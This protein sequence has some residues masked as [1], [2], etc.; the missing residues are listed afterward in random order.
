MKEE[1]YEKNQEDEKH[2]EKEKYANICMYS[3]S[4]GKKEFEK[5][6]K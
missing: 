6:N 1:E 4:K 2:I 3:D 5:R